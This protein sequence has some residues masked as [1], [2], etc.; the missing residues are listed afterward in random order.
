M[1]TIEAAGSFQNKVNANEALKD[2]PEVEKVIVVKRLGI[3]VPFVKRKGC[4]VA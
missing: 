2:C 4:L 3:D 1:A